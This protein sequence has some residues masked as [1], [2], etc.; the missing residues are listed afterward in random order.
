MATYSGAGGSSRTP[1][2]AVGAALVVREGDV[3]AGVVDRLP[4][5]GDDDEPVGDDE[6][7][8]GDE[9]VGGDEAVEGSVVPWLE[10]RLL[11]GA[12]S[13]LG[14]CDAQALVINNATSRIRGLMSLPPRRECARTLR[15]GGAP[16]SASCRKT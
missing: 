1:S 3:A 11:D 16:H 2:D 12:G 7:V 14:G 10:D 9:A 6:A 4:V 5:V 8:E 15:A 13:A